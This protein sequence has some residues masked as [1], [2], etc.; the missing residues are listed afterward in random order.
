M[1]EKTILYVE[2][3]Y[4][5]RRIVR[6]ILG[7]RGYTIVE[8]E[9]GLMGYEMICE[10]K[11][12]L[13]LLDIALPHLDGIEIV[14]RL[15][16]DSETAHIPVIALTASAM[17]GDRE[18]FL[19]AG[20]DD[21]LSKPVRAYELVEMVD[22][23][24]V[25]SN[26]D[27]DSEVTDEPT[28]VAVAGTEPAA[29][30]A[31]EAAEDSHGKSTVAEIQVTPEEG[32]PKKAKKKTT[33]TKL[34]K[35]T[36]KAK[37]KG[38]ARGKKA[39]APA[40]SGLKE[41]DVGYNDALSSN[42]AEMLSEEAIQPAAMEGSDEAETETPPV[43]AGIENGDKVATIW[44]MDESPSDARLMRRLIGAKLKVEAMEVSP[45][46]EILSSAGEIPILILFG[47]DKAC[48]RM[49]KILDSI[50]LQDHTANVPIILLSNEDLGDSDYE[51]AA[52]FVEMAWTKDKLMN[53]DFL[54]N[55]SAILAKKSNG[56]KKVKREV[57][58]S[59]PNRAPEEGK[60]RD[61]SVLVIEDIPDSAALAKKILDNNDYRVFVADNGE[62]GLK[63][64]LEHRPDMILLDLGLPDVD[65]QTLLGI[66]RAE[67]SLEGTPI[68][69][70]TAWPEESLKDIVESYGFDDYISK[71]YKVAEFMTVVEA[72]TA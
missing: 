72:H 5:N 35:K 43:V 11:P 31:D 3:N 42:M 45:S 1:D 29:A 33:K 22:K 12:P 27:T 15:K 38:A 68:I 46:S 41:E 10:M 71:P 4:H 61:A 67:D 58:A 20:C 66:L 40:A 34:K 37:K 24:F 6:K 53:A 57:V 2:D 26:G 36:A 9:D 49:Y 56:K 52:K 17:R 32:K 50:R 64:A 7:T 39:A 8:A 47:V 65:G 51:N 19:E 59:Q 60:N 55:I 62:M 44:V 28:E 70:C 14:K 18:R 48:D 21:Y 30:V 54:K 16:A 25:N 63:M 23:Y 69:V 13:V